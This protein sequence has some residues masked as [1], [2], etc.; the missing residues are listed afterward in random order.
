MEERTTFQGR[1]VVDTI[2][3]HSNDM[4]S[5]LERSNDME[6]VPGDGAIA[7]RHIFEDHAEVLD[8]TRVDNLFDLCPGHGFVLAARPEGR[9]VHLVNCLLGEGLWA[10]RRGASWGEERGVL[11]VR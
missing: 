3:S 6:L 11:L 2:A 10:S 9:K 7:N 4:A 5:R 8:A 1:A